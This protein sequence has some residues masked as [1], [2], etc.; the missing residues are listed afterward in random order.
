V[1]YGW[2]HSA[3]NKKLSVRVSSQDRPAADAPGTRLHK[4]Q[5]QSPTATASTFA[6][7]ALAVLR[8]R[9]I[10]TTQS[11]VGHSPRPASNSALAVSTVSFYNALW[12]CCGQECWQIV[13]ASV[14]ASVVNQTQSNLT[15]S[16]EYELG[17]NRI[18]KSGSIVLLVK[19]V[20][21]RHNRLRRSWPLNIVFYEYK[22]L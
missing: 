20:T 11:P 19:T 15:V 1:L 6:E 3:A 5:H 16:G 10:T 17:K 14:F 18:Q 21:T 7:C 22:P 2:L 4:H 12:L 9:I 8:S 13:S